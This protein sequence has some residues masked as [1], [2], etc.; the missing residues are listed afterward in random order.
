MLSYH[1]SPLAT[2]GGK[3]SGGM[4]VYVRELSTHLARRGHRVDVFTRG[5][6]ETIQTIVDGARVISLPAGPPRQIEKNQLSAFIPEFSERVQDFA[7]RENLRYDIIHAHYW[8]SGLV[9]AQLKNAWNV[10]IVVMFH[11]LGLV[12]NRITV[13]G[14]RESDERI[15]GERRVLADA[16]VVVAA[17]PAEQA[18]LQ[19]LYE[20]NSR[21]ASVI[22]P[23]VDLDQFHPLDQ[24]EA[25]TQ[26]ALHSDERHILFVGRIEALKGIDTLIRA[27]H[28]MVLE[29]SPE[30]HVQVIGGDVEEDLE[31]LTS[32]MSRLRQLVSQLGLKENIQFLGSRRQREL[33]TYYA[34]ADVVVMPSYSE[35]FG[36]VA[37]EAMACGR[38][39]IASRVG[40]LAYLVQD[41]VTGFHIQEGNA[42]EMATRLTVLL[43]NEVLLNS[44]GI[45][46]RRE[47]EKYS[48]GKVA[49][50]MEIL[51]KSLQ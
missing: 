50:E 37:L 21:K 19:W 42:E 3:H 24:T 25:R 43:G 51:Y 28:L 7:R 41:G 15:R 6:D 4:N 33:P 49:D 8:M 29:G 11:T 27:A 2:L 5:I 44:F 40:G 35:S 18:D 10:P 16:D 47:A 22:P 31:Q 12:K 38:P 17:T 45:A 46:A 13:L 23:G 34:A 48:W 14:E 26:L 1:T 20:L 9:G 39:V 30:F 32:E 36:M